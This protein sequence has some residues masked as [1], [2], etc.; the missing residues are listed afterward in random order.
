MPHSRISAARIKILKRPDDVIAS[1]ADL[2]WHA[3]NRAFIVYPTD[4]V[5]ALGGREKAERIYLW[6]YGLRDA[7]VLSPEHLA[8]VSR[9]LRTCPSDHHLHQLHVAL[10]PSRPPLPS[11][12]SHPDLGKFTG[13][14]LGEAANELERE[15]REIRALIKIRAEIARGESAE[16]QRRFF[17]R[18]RERQRRLGRDLWLLKLEAGRRQPLP[19]LQLGHF[20]PAVLAA[21]RR[22][23]LCARALDAGEPWFGRHTPFSENEIKMAFEFAFKVVDEIRHYWQSLRKSNRTFAQ[24]RDETVKKFPGLN[25]KYMRRKFCGPDYSDLQLTEFVTASLTSLSPGTIRVKYRTL[26]A[27]PSKTRI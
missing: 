27:A 26:L 6:S 16:T 10:R 22:D 1:Y 25:A 17:A 20:S 14:D 19:P 11:T 3:E 13:R 8:M 7:T 12:R 24:A 21:A 15:D 18:V 9:L 5:E 23:A 2:K 4:L